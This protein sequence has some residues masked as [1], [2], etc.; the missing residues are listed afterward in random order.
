MSEITILRESCKGV[1]DCGICIHVCPEE[2]LIQ[3][4]HMNERGYLPP[5]IRAERL[6]TG[7]QRCMVSCPDFA[8]IV[9]KAKGA[10]WADEG[11]SDG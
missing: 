9:E 8:I 10:S 6:C 2:V 5:A 3:S 1:E 7:C 4:A 11:H